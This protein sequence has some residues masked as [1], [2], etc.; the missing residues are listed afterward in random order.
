MPNLLSDGSLVCS[1]S[2]ERP[3]PGPGGEGLVAPSD[4][5][6]FAAG[7]ER[8]PLPKDAG[9]FGRDVATEDYAPLTPPPGH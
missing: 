5:P 7:Q 6:G 2:A 9:Q 8:G 1:C 4:A 3:L